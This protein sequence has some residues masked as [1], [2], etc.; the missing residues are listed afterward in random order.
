MRRGNGH[1]RET[2]ANLLLEARREPDLGHQ[3]QGLLAAFERLADQAQVDLGLPAARNALQ[4]DGMEGAEPFED[5]VQGA[6]LLRSERQ[7]VL[8]GG[9]PG[10]R[11]DRVDGPPA[12]LAKACWQGRADHFA[13]GPQVIPRAE[14]EQLELR[15]GQGRHVRDHALHGF[16]A[17]RG[18]GAARR[19]ADHHTHLPGASEGHH[20][21]VSGHHLQVFRQREIERFVE[22]DIER[23]AGDFHCGNRGRKPCG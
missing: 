5:R 10:R 7:R 23:D 16:Q 2:L 6:L 1:A 13:Q 19:D 4:E 22:G 15:S 20:D 11:D 18:N 21:E 14:F 17:G 3:E 12:N 8:R 9:L